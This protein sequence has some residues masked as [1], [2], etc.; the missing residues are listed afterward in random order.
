MFIYIYIYCVC[1]CVCVYNTKGRAVH[2]IWVCTKGILIFQFVTRTF[3][4]CLIVKGI[5]FHSVTKLKKL[6]L[7]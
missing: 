5:C 2:F 7:N 3:I 1:V 6:Q 4:V